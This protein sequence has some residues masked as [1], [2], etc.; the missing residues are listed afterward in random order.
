MVTGSWCDAS[1]YIASRHDQKSSAACASG[2]GPLRR[3]AQVALE[4]VGV[5]VDHGR[6]LER[7][8]FE[9]LQGAEQGGR[10]D[11]RVRELHVLVG[12]VADAR[13]VADED[14]AR[15]QPLGEDARVVPG[16]AH[17]LGQLAEGVAHGRVEGDARA[18]TRRRA[19]RPG[20]R[21][22][23][24]CRASASRQASSRAGS[25]VRASIHSRTRAG[26][27]VNAFGS[28][29][30][31][32]AVTRKSGSSPASSSAATISRA[33]AARASARS[34]RRVVPAWSARPCSSSAS[35]IRDASPRTAPAGRAEP[36]EIARLVDVQ[37]HEAA[38][39]REPR[40]R[41]GQ[42]LGVGA[43]A[44]HRVGERHAVVVAA[45]ERVGDVEPAD[46][47]ARAERRRVEAR[48]LL[49]GEGEHGDARHA[50]RDRE[51]RGDAQRPVEAPAGAHAVEVR[52]RRPPRPVTL[53][54]RPERAR[55]VA[56]DAQPG[57][58]R[59]ARGT[60]PR[61]PRAP[62]SRR[63]GRRRRS[64]IPMASSPASRSRSSSAPI[65]TASPARRGRAARGRA[66]RPRSPPRR[67]CGRGG[68]GCAPRARRAAGRHRAPARR[69][70]TQAALSVDASS[71][72]R[73][74]Q[75]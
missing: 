51:A 42:R 4:G 6:Q 3:A 57:R 52:A 30:I 56:R 13:R 62:R 25:G 53:R 37:L 26:T 33:A 23:A 28:T 73:T 16:E 38:Q 17:E 61:P 19:G 34:C 14:H 46:E 71:A 66:R 55:G 47:R 67:G 36:L 40:G 5:R 1:A 58:A 21:R 48:A 63:A 64:R 54:Q 27:V 44:P 43:E 60:R 11:G 20:P 9:G 18:L 12:G 72:S 69:P 39:A 24:A 7:G 10:R 2:A 68:R 59:P 22:R 41:I 74:L 29:R 31:R 50:L 70:S 75:P 8:H 45:G 65:V 32:E 35:R 15:G 49:V